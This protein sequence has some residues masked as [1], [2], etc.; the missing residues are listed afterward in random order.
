MF[1]L[2]VYDGSFG[3]CCEGSDENTREQNHVREITL[4]LRKLTLPEGGKPRSVGGNPGSEGANLRSM[5]V[6]PT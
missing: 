6:N 5:G 1:L 2:V 3:W 4:D